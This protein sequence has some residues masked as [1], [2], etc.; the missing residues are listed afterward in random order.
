MTR[1][2]AKPTR[3]R[4][5]VAAEIAALRGELA[6]MRQLISERLPAPDGDLISTTAAG[7]LCGRSSE[8]VRRWA[9]KEGVG[10]FSPAGACYLVSRLGCG[11][12]C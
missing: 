10:T 8:T 3:V 5:S 7:R 2:A 12:S 9:I 6:Q 1:R 4:V 11:R